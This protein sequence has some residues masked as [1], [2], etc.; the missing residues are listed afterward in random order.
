MPDRGEYITHRAEHGA[1]N[2]AQF[3][4][5]RR[6]ADDRCRDDVEFVA[7]SESRDGER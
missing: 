3:H 7:H 5:E 2:G 6:A 4:G 1:G